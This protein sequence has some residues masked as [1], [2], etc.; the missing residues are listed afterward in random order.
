MRA[1]VAKIGT[2]DSDAT[3]GG[4]LGFAENICI[5]R[6]LI[7]PNELYSLIDL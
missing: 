5:L 1:R 3:I 6:L 2:I 7:M 4:Y